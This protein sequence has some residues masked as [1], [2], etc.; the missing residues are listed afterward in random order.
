MNHNDFVE[1]SKRFLEMLEVERNVSVHTLRSYNTDIKQF[2]IFWQKLPNDDAQTIS[3]RQILERYLVSL[4]Y[5]KIK[6]STIARKISCFKSFERFLRNH[7]IELYLNIRRPRIEKNVPIYL[8]INEINHLLNNINNNDLPS[9]FP[10]R[11]KAIL[12]LLYATG[13][14][15]S[16][17][18]AI[19][20]NDI[21]ESEKTI[22]IHGKGNIERIALYGDHAARALHNYLHVERPT[23]LTQQ[24]SLFVNHRNQKLTTRSIQ[25]II[26]M[27]RT[28]LK[29]D[30]PITPHKI[31]H[32]FATHLLNRGADLRVVQELLGH[33]TLSSTE[34]YTHISLQDLKKICATIHP[35]KN[36]SHDR[37]DDD[38]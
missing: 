11:D 27:F 19:T 26:K 31:R 9:K 3:V 4:H 38:E 35:L 17:L 37:N 21:N 24:E 14:R 6:K 36:I 16:E 22:R 32:S 13:I 18:V 15:C 23:V 29:T 10:L 8:T 28:F 25:R 34:K 5:K 1:Q 20:I 33:K 30:R 7:N 2:L 12:E